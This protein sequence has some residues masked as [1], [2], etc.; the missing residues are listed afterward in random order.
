[1][2]S[3]YDQDGY[4]FLPSFVRANIAIQRGLVGPIIQRFEQRG[5][6]FL[7]PIGH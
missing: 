3:R 7:D 6:V 2:V 1:M 5:Y 4:T